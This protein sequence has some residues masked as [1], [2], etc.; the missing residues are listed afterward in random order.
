MTDTDPTR[1]EKRNGILSR[2]LP[3]E[4][5]FE[6]MLLSQAQATL[7]GVEAFV[8]W[9]GSGCMN[10]P[11]RVREIEREVDRMRYDLEET[12]IDAFSTPFDRED[13]YSLSRQMDYILNYASETAREMY[14]FG[15][16]P[17]PAIERMGHLLLEGTG[18]VVEG[19]RVM[20]TDETRVRTNIRTAR[21]AMHG[22]EDAYIDG[23]VVL[24]RESD[25][26]EAL[27]RREVYHHLR[28]GG[29]ALRAT[30]DVLHRAVVGL[31]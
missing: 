29:R 18:A 14:A 30:V 23:L 2:L 8:T 24:F 4:H 3:P 25:A 15:V 22:I 11:G 27:R 21:A 5:D 26:M 12:L 28:D 19:V 7:S 10:P 6:G 17:D 31:S 1:N 9:L 16:G 20:T 13:L